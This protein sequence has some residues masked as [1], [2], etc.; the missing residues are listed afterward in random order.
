MIERIWRVTCDAPDCNSQETPGAYLDALTG[1]QRLVSTD[2]IP[3][4]ARTR[5]LLVGQFELHFCPEHVGYLGVHEPRTMAAQAP[6]R[7]AKVR[8]WCACNM[9]HV[10]DEGGWHRADSPGPALHTERLWWEHLPEEL[11]AYATWRAGREA[12][13]A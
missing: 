12:A 5:S 2:H 4:D 9:R 8:I 1:W 6:G 13:T 10:V 3:A 7:P 11:Q